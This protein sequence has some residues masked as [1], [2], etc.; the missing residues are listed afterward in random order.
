MV[1]AVAIKSDPS[2]FIESE[3][4]NATDNAMNENSFASQDWGDPGKNHKNLNVW[5]D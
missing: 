4:V 1:S 2:R 3:A 5:S